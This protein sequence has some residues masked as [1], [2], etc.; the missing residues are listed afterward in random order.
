MWKRR[1]TTLWR[2]VAIPPQTTDERN[3]YFLYAEIVFASILSAAGSFNSAY[4]LR[5]GGSNAMIGLM[6]SLPALLAMVC[7]I[8]SAGFLER[9]TRYMP[10]LVGSLLLS[11][12]GYLVIPLLAFFLQGALPQITVAILISMTIPSVFFSTAWSPLLSD[13]VPVRSRAT[14]LSWRSILS[15]ATIAPLIF[16]AGRWLDLIPFPANYQWMYILC[17]LGGAFSVY[18]VS[19]IKPP[20]KG[21]SAPASRPNRVPW[22]DMLGISLLRENRAFFR[23]VSNT[24]LYNMGSWMVGPLY[25]ILFV[26]QLGASDGWVGMNGTLANVGVIVGYWAWR[27]IIR[28]TGE[29]KAMLIALPLACVYPFLVAAV[30]HLTFILLAGFLINLINPGVNLSHSM[31]FLNLLPEGKK[32]TSTAVYSTIMNVGAFIAPLVGVALSEVIG[33]V[34]TLVVGG[35][36]SLVGASLF[37]LFPV[38]ARPTETPAVRG[39]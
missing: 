25:I 34:P 29:T 13:V 36:M 20:E 4:V 11:R 9:R 6:S 23:I 12:S 15:S 28:K 2:Q 39:I 10:W 8:P 17:F 30:P 1:L 32:L 7:Y 18:L 38:V 26:R 24:L 37:Y 3:V 16:L 27:R 14:V 19:R 22:R 21:S 33:I 5:L 35:V 31:I